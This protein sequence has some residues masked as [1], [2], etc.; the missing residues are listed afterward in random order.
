MDPIK[1]TG[2][3]DYS[4]A[5]PQNQ[6]QTQAYEDY[7]TAPMVYDPEMEDKKKASSNMLG[8][9]ALGLL[10]IGGLGYGIAK[11]RKVGDLKKQVTDLTTKNETL[12]KN[13]EAAQAQLEKMVP[14]TEEGVKE[15]NIFK[16]IWNKIKG[17]S[18]PK[19]APTA[20]TAKPEV[21]PEVKPEAKPESETKKD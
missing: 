16:R 11:G 2:V 18:K 17:K 5:V 3:A 4:I 1:N 9:T 8:M 21:K 7:S 12:T 10:A 20:E 14:K 6:Y 15:K 13:L 19:E